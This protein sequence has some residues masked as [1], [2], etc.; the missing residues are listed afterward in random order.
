MATSDGEL[1]ERVAA[2]EQS[3][4]ELLFGRW[5][6]VALVD[7]RREGEGAET[8]RPASR[9]V[10]ARSGWRAGPHVRAL[11]PPLILLL[12]TALAGIA[13]ELAAPSRPA[14]TVAGAPTPIDPGSCRDRASSRG[15]R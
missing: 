4:L 7:R 12:S 14:E 1:M 2:G 3:A 11:V 13:L 8:T 15:V 10:P 6:P 9:A 5:S